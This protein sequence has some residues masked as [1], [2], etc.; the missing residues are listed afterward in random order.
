MLTAVVPAVAKSR[1]AASMSVARVRALDRD[2]V[3]SVTFFSL[4]ILLDAK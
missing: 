2:G 3:F 4:P 1:A